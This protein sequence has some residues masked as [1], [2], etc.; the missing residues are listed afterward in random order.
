MR[1][2]EISEPGRPRGAEARR[3]AGSQAWPRPDPDP[4]GLGGR[5]PARCAA[6]CRQL[7]A[8]ARRV[9]PAGARGGGRGGRGRRRVSP[10]GRW[11]TQVCALLPGGGY[12]EYAVTPA[13]HALP[14]AGR[15]WPCARRPACPRPSSPSGPTSSTRGGLR[16]GERFLVH[17]GSLGHRHDGDPARGAIRRPRLRDRRLGRE[18]RRL[19]RPGRRA[20]DQLP[21]GGFRRGAAR[22]GR[23]RPDPRHGGRRLHR[24]QRA[25]AGR[26]R[27]AGPDRVPAGAE[28]RAEL[29]RR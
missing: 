5:E 20:R 26:R 3:A 16:A 9:R 6:A 15:A 11:A 25:G 27:A 18:M 28:G 29:R 19:H 14:R 13:A 22:G 21:R 8:A 23:R 1:A 10:N 4:S 12:A 17:G 2:V 7:C 24:P